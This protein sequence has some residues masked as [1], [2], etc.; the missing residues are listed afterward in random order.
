MASGSGFLCPL[1]VRDM[2]GGA[3]SGPSLGTENDMN[4]HPACNINLKLNQ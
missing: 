4:S 3:V 1:S 2:A